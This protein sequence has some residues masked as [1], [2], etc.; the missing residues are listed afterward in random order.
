MPS[1]AV[2][3]MQ[4]L[5]AAPQKSPDCPRRICRRENRCMP[6][7]DRAACGLQ[8]CRFESYSEWEARVPVAWRKYEEVLK[9]VPNVW[10]QVQAALKEA[11]EPPK[12]ASAGGPRSGRGGSPPR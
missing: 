6:P 1:P 10:A 12:K 5:I 2:A 4:F 3:Y 7:P 11:E 8:R 9:E